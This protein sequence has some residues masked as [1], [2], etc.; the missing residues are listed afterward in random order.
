MSLPFNSKT[1]I[2]VQWETNEQPTVASRIEDFV[3]EGVKFNGH[4]PRGGGT[5]PNVGYNGCHSLAII[6]NQEFILNA[7]D[8]TRQAERSA[9]MAA[10]IEESALRARAAAEVTSA[11]GPLLEKLQTMEQKMERMEA[12][13]ASIDNKCCTIS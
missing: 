10:V 2:N 13:L 7:I 1:H 6:C 8:P 12:K 9:Q 3:Q 11:A 4:K 5:L